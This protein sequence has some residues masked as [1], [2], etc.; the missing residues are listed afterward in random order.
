MRIGGMIG[1]VLGFDG[2]F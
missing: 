2:S 1:R